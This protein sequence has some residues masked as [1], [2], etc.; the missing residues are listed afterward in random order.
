MGNGTSSE[1]SGVD[2]R[3]MWGWRSHP[4]P[5]SSEPEAVAKAQPVL[6]LWR[7]LSSRL[8]NIYMQGGG[9]MNAAHNKISQ[10]C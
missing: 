9:G 1:A 4:A 8:K 10:N 6:V 3:L 5:V 2:D 7:G